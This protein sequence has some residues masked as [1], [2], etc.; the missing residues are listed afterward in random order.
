MTISPA[1]SPPCAPP[2]A[3]PSPPDASPDAG[4]DIDAGS[5]A[6]AASEPDASQPDHP[7][8]VADLVIN[9]IQT[10]GSSG[11]DEFI[12]LRNRCAGAVELTGA[13]LVY[14]SANAS[15]ASDTTTLAILGGTL[16][17][18]GYLV[19]A[20]G[21]FA[22]NAQVRPLASGLSASAGA[23]GLRDSAGAL[24][25]SVGWGATSNPLVEGTAAAAPPAGRSIARS[26]DSADSNQNAADF[27][28]DPSPSAGAAN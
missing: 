6:D 9:E 1:R 20:G 8:A 5:L 14:R 10:G 22:G 28:V 16:A 26:A 4:V 24:V 2:P 18:G 27:T 15:G 13:R 25:D 11:T 17:A 3:T 23:V 21:G 19:A 7:C 12:E